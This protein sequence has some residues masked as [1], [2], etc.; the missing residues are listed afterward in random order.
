MRFFY[1]QISSTVNMQC[2]NF[3]AIF[4]MLIGSLVAVFVN[5]GMLSEQIDWKMVSL[6]ERSVLTVEDIH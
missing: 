3:D 6:F 5:I 4:S 2:S 1:Q